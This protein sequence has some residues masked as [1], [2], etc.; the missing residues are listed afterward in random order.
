M[1]L[2]S[3]IFLQVIVNITKTRSIKE[4]RDSKLHSLW[5][6]VFSKELFRRKQRVNNPSRITAEQLNINSVRKQF[7]TLCCVFK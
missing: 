3:L 2:L 1:C 5:R 6:Q 7:D 4:F